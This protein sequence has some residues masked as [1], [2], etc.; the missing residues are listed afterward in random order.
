MA[1]I[2]CDNQCESCGRYT[3]VHFNGGEYTEFH[4]PIA[5]KYVK[6]IYDENGNEERREVDAWDEWGTKTIRST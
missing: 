3:S 5:H 6:I 1:H 4:C 2:T